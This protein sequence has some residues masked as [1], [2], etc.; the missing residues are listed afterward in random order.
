MAVTELVA[1][2]AQFL[3]PDVKDGKLAG[4]L[5]QLGTFGQGGTA[6]DDLVDDRVVILYLEQPSHG[7]DR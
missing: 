4:D 3:G 5:G 6:M 1:L 2:L 7:P